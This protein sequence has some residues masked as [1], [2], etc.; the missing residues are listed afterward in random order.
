[1]IDDVNLDVLQSVPTE[2]PVS[3]LEGI[4]SSDSAVEDVAFSLLSFRR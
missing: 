4:I 1:M 2:S 3:G